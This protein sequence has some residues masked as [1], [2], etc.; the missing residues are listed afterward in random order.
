MQSL[1]FLLTTDAPNVDS[2][3][4][5]KTW[6]ARLLVSKAVSEEVLFLDAN[7]KAEKNHF[8]AYKK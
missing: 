6:I 4:R 7:F 1:I 3:A 2:N 8:K 5:V